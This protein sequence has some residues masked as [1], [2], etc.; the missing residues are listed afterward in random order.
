MQW[1]YWYFYCEGDEEVQYQQIFYIVGYWCIQQFFIVE[2]LYV[3]CV[4]VYKDQCQDGNQYYQIICLG[5]DEEFGCCC[6]MCFFVRSFVVLQ[7]YQ[8]VYWYQYYFLE[9]EEQEYVDGQE[10]VDNVV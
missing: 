8:E 2:G 6:D 5:V 9:E 3:G 7:C 1:N 4:V 10:Y